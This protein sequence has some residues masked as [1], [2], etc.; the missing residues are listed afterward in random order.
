VRALLLL[1][2]LLLPACG[3]EVAAALEEEWAVTVAQQDGQPLRV[4]DSLPADGILG[5]AHRSAPYFLFNRPLDAAEIDALGDLVMAE[6]DGGDSFTFAPRLAFDQ[7]AVNYGEDRLNRPEAYV[8]DVSLPPGAGAW[9]SGFAT[10]ELPGP[11]FNASAGMSATAFGGNEE[12]A[13]LLSSYF[14]A[15]A[16]VWLAKVTG[17]AADGTIDVALAVTNGASSG[18][19]PFYIHRAYGYVTR[20]PGMALAADGSFEATLDGALL[21]LWISGDPVLLRLTPLTIRGRFDPSGPALSDFELEGVVETRSLLK[22]SELPDPWPRLLD[23]VSLDVDTNGNG[24]ED[25]AT[26]H[27][28]SQPALVPRDQIDFG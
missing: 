2:H 3:A 14:T 28:V 18:S 27:L 16:P 24:V 1:A 19:R 11:D 26:I 9:H 21:P 7:A 20:F 25:S 12:H 4:V 13:A 22:M 8:I 10:D 17:P 15:G 23:I 6:A 5:V